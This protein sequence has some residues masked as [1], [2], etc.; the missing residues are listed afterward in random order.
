[1]KVA[2]RKPWGY[3]F[4]AYQ[5]EHVAI[6]HLVISPW[7]ET[8]LHCHPNKKTGLI[9]LQGA[10]KVSFLSGGEKLFAGEKI[11]I[12]E[13]VF[14]RTKN[15]TGHRL[16]LLEIESPVD[17]ADLVRIDDKYNRGTA[18]T[19]EDDYDIDY[20][21]SWEGGDLAGDCK[22]EMVKMEF[23]IADGNYLLL[24]GGVK[25]GSSFV[26]APGDIVSSSTFKML[27]DRFEPFETEAIRVINENVG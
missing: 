23:P 4:L 22:V 24:S 25:C 16:E 18:Y 15:M 13:G 5:N 26:C 9:V 14:H 2:K 11:M 3:E 8:S 10:A 20:R 19:D 6:W 12:R 21:Y 7:A 17:K 27:S 1:M